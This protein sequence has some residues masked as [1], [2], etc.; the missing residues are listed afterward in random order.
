MKC[1]ITELEYTH[2][3]IT[4]YTAQRQKKHKGMVRRHSGGED[5]TVEK[6]RKAVFKEK[7]ED[8]QDL[9]KDNH[10]PVQ[11]AQ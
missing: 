10:P 3:E 2:K 4:G 1:R 7:A 11:E 5:Q 6:R 9:I 8:F